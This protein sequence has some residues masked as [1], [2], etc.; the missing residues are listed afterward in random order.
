V[1]EWGVGERGLAIYTT[2]ITAAV[3]GRTKLT[4]RGDGEEAVH[5]VVADP[6]EM[7][8]PSPNAEVPDHLRAA[9]THPAVDAAPEAPSAPG[10]AAPPDATPEELEELERQMKLLGYM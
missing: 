6:L 7:G 8:A 3:D 2:D 5:D 10:P 4:V 1:E 9:L